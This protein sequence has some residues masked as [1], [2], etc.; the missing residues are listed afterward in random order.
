MNRGKKICEHLKVVR[1]Q[2]ADAND[3]PYEMTECT[4]QGPC[5]GTCPKCESELRYI[6]N[7]LSLRRAAG[8]AVSIVGLSLGISSAFMASGCTPTTKTT[9]NVETQTKVVE[10]KKMAKGQVN[11]PLIDSDECLDIEELSDSDNC[12]NGLI[13]NEPSLVPNNKTVYMVVDYQPEFPGGDKALM[14]FIKTNLRYPP[15][16]CAQGRVTVTFIVETD[17]SISNIEV[18]KSP[19]EEFSQEAIRVVKL[20]PKWKPGKIKDTP[21]RVKYILPISFRLE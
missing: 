17:G 3:I 16:T 10:D 9:E 8:K 20:M 21:V 11:P 12:I 15:E 4:H 14:D 19:V 18:L 6:E 1:K 5:A 7:Q 13:S 2:I